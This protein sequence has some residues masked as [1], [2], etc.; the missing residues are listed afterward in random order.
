MSDE[1]QP[2]QLVKLWEKKIGSITV[3][4]YQQGKTIAIEAGVVLAARS[5]YDELAAQDALFDIEHV[6]TQRALRMLKDE[7]ERL[8][9]EMNS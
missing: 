5:A 6:A 4:A 8:L 1:Q 3:V 9:A 7:V 2:A